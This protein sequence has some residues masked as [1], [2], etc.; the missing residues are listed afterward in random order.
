M[1]EKTEAQKLNLSQKIHVMEMV[2]Q[3][4]SYKFKTL[5]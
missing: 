3:V 2:C 4:Q 1:S 5:D